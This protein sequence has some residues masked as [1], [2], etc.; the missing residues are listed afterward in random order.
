MLNENMKALRKARG[1]SQEELA[2]K[3][4]VV[5]QT[6]SKWEKGRSVPDAGMVIQIA[7]VL[8]TTVQVLLGEELP[9]SEGPDLTKTLAA[10]LEVL[11]GQYSKENERRRKIWRT[12]FAAVFLVSA[13]SLIRYFLF[14]ASLYDLK[15]M[16]A[17]SADVAVIGGGDVP[18]SISIWYTFSV[19]KPVLLRVLAALASAIGFYRTGPK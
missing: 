13:L 3:L 7:E 5:R 19:W 15:N 18:A 4:N 8:G 2:F 11:N 10:K 1:L 9:V 12:V 6:V 17:A 16:A 14:F